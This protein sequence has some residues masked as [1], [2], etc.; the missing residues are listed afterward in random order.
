VSGPPAAVTEVLAA[1]RL[2]EGAQVIGPVPVDG[3]TER[4]LVRVPR[5]AGAELGARLKEATAGRSARRSAEP[6][7]IQ[8]D[9]QEL[10]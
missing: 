8:L 3:D 5:A 9:P 7:R 4:V 1:A 6:V 10:V 2:P